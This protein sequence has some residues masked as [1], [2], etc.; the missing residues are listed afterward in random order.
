MFTMGLSLTGEY[1]LM[2]ANAQL[3]DDAEF[4]CQVMATE[5]TPPL[6][7]RIAKLTILGKLFFKHT[8]IFTFEDYVASLFQSLSSKFF[9]LKDTTIFTFVFM[10]SA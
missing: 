7:S 9:Y 5:T 4:Q 10:N 1:D 3:E 8:T 2:V 6:T